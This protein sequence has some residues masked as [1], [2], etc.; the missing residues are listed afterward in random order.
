[1]NNFETKLT[2]LKQKFAPDKRTAIF[3]FD[4]ENSKLIKTDQK[5]AYEELMDFMKMNNIKSDDY[6][7]ELLPSKELGDK[8]YGIVNISVANLRS[9]PKHPAEL[10]TQALLGDPVKVL[11]DNNDY[12]FRIQ[13]SDN[14]IAWTDD[15]GFHPMNKKEFDN[16]INAKKIVYTSSC[17]FS[18][19]EKSDNS[20]RVSDLVAGNLL[21]YLDEDDNFYHV[22]YPDGRKAYVNKN[23]A[24]IFD[25]WFSKAEATQKTIVN[26]AK[27]F[28]G[29]PY[30]WGGTSFKGVDCS[31]F[32]KTV[33]R[34]NGVIL[35]RDASQQVNTG[36][37]VDTH[38]KDFSKLEP[39]DLLFF[40][41]HAKEGKRERVTHVAIYIGG[42]EFIHAS[43]KVKIN[44]LDPKAD[45]FSKFRYSQFIRAK[46]ILNSIDTFGISTFKSN[47]YYNGDLYETE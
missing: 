32:T 22:E 11:E 9:D 40:G 45:N 10:A 37:L 8:I 20:Q 26:T 46:R 14:Y 28:M 7:V 27:T 29:L 23:D 30:L 34:L 16:W 21:K 2:E 36:V 38:D 42:G 35:Q 39:G 6:N 19:I 17:G 12:W 15:D 31:G 43:G 18:Y 47:K 25:E 13:T 3:E 24:Q 4:L 1:M 44:S 33:F 41:H 5:Q